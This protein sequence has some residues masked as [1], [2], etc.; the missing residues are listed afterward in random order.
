M[1]TVAAYITVY[2][3]NL[4]IHVAMVVVSV[5][6]ASP[7]AARCPPPERRR[8]FALRTKRPTL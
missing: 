8:L 4:I 2:D 5:G 6:A 7:A 1:N 3:I